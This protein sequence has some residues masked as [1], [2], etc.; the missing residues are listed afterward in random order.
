VV[1]PFTI[2]LVEDDIDQLCATIERIR[3]AVSKTSA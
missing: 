2:L 3:G 1:R